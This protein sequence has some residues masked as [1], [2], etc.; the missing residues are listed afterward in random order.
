MIQTFR[1][2]SYLEGIS[3]LLLLGIGVPLKYLAGNDAWVKA[4]GMPH[5]LLF[6]A[7]IVLAYVVKTKLHWNSSTFILV[8]AASIIPFGTFYVDRKYLKKRVNS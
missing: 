7:Y 6:M 8:L 4:L 2:V 1:I 3:Y 5:G